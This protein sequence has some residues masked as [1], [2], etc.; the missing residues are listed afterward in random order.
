MEDRTDKPARTKTIDERELFEHIIESSTDFAIFTTDLDGIVTSWNTGARRLFGYSDDEILGINDDVTFTPEDRATSAPAGERCQA[1]AEGCAL[2]DRWHMRKDGSRFWA[3]GLLMP[4]RN[5]VDGFVKVT[6]DRT[7][8]YR[9]DER[10]RGS[11]AR[12]RLLAT[13]IPQLVFCCRPDGNRSWGSPQWCDFVGMSLDESLGFG[14]LDAV[15][16]DDREG[17]LNAWAEAQATGEYYFEHRVRRSRDGEYLWHQ[18]RAK[19][20]N[21]EAGTDGEWVGTMTDIDDLRGLQDRQ[22]VLMAEL[23]HRTRNLLAVVQAI[24]SQTRRTSASVTEFGN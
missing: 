11:E 4:L 24:A 15:H 7:E 16:P 22:Q 23:L 2:D 8:Q 5:P 17:S 13:A 3:S 1:L 18:T 20:V 12:F 6:R 21:H 14:W 10:L 19:P 9:A